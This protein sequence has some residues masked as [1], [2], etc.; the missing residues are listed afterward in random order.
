MWGQVPIAATDVRRSVGGIYIYVN[1]ANSAGGGLQW[2]AVERFTIG[3][4]Y[5][6]TD[7]N[8]ID[9]ITQHGY[10]MNTGVYKCSGYVR[11]GGAAPSK[12]AARWHGYVPD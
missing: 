2:P 7:F 12:T 4:Q 8:Y 3:L 1:T 11:Y 10:N 6:A 9:I 5:P